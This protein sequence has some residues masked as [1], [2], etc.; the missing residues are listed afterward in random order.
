MRILHVTDTH[1][2]ETIGRRKLGYEPILAKWMWCCRLAKRRGCRFVVHTGDVFHKSLVPRAVEQEVASLIHASDVPHILVA[3]NHDFG[4]GVQSVSGKSFASIMTTRK[5]YSSHP[6]ITVMNNN[7]DITDPPRL[8]VWPE[9]PVLCTHHM[10]VPSPVPWDHHILTDLSAFGAKV[11]LC[12][13]YHDGWPEP[14]FHDGAWWSNPGSLTRI[15]HDKTAI[16]CALIDVDEN[17]ASVEY[18]ALPAFD[19]YD[20]PIVRPWDE[21]YDAGGLEQER[22]LQQVR[23]SLT[24]AIK[25]ANERNID[26]YAERLQEIVDAPFQLGDKLTAEL[27]EAGANALLKLC[28]QIESGE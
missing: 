27:V 22:K 19:E 1:I 16:R 9:K 4:S 2:A 8:N 15:D 5:V 26:G 7:V 23:Q 6:M 3:G 18:I 20:C 17:E 11:V 12:G 10:I 21:V 24:A 25:A 13:D 14:I 28:E